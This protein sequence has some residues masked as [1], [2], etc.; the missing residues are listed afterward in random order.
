MSQDDEASQTKTPAKALG[1][2]ERCGRPVILNKFT[3]CYECR[4]LEKADVER[5]LDYLKT[6]RGASL[7]Q[8]ADAVKVDPQLVLR[9]IRGGRMEVQANERMKKNKR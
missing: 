6:H 1:G 7:Q 9:L 2:C 4:A 3:L 5:A 8:V